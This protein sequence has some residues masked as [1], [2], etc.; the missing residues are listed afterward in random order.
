MSVLD[1][2]RT[3]LRSRVEPPLPGPVPRPGARSEPPTVPFGSP[4]GRVA[5]P[6]EVLVADGAGGQAAERVTAALEERGLR[7]RRITAD[8]L[9]RPAGCVVM[10]LPMTRT[11]PPAESP[12]GEYLA[13]LQLQAS[14]P[15]AAAR[16]TAPVLI[17]WCV[18]GVDRAVLAVPF[19]PKRNHAA[20]LLANAWTTELRCHADS[21]LAAVRCRSTRVAGL[22]L[23]HGVLVDVPVRDLLRAVDTLAGSWL[24]SLIVH[25][26]GSWSDPAAVVAAVAA[27]THQ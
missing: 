5:A 19:P 26:N 25:T 22:A 20:V 1:R 2:F 21:E 24:H 8:E 16:F 13:M 9:G 6:D 11:A 23:D 14:D 7:C 10:L 12:A 17:V 15:A 3:V 27:L 4:A 18:R